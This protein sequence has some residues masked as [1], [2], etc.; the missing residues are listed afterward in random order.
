MP[1]K[2]RTESNELKLLRILNTRMDLSAEVKKHYLNLE[3]GYEGEVKFDLLTEKLQ[4]ECF[5]LNDLLL[6]LNNS[7]VQI[8]TTI[9]FQQTVNFFEVKNFNGDFTLENGIFKKIKGKE[10]QNPVDQVNRGKSFLRPLLKDLGCNLPIE[11]N[12]VFI[13]PEFTL[14]HASPNLPF[15][16]PS[17]LNL[18]MKKL[19]IRQSS[20]NHQHKLLAE[21]LVFLHQTKSPFSIQ[22][23]Y[24]YKNFH[25]GFTC[26]TAERLT[27]LFHQIKGL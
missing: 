1:F 19:N 24:E 7:N 17:Q 6:K 5:I 11:A 4:S 21:K 26:G 16:F 14:Y 8:D 25:K 10:Y 9:I 18:Y 13:N 12:A 2:T 23:E 27:Y 20:L 15:I 3:K 22:P